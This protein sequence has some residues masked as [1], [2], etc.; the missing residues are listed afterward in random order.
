MA[1]CMVEQQL[2]RCAHFFH[3]VEE[4]SFSGYLHDNQPK[5]RTEIMLKPEYLLTFKS[6]KK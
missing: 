3:D 5:N 2:C 4:T 6:W 1:Y